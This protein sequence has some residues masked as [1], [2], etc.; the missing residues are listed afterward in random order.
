MVAELLP[1]R[2]LLLGVVEVGRCRAAL[3]RPCSERAAVLPETGRAARDDEAPTLCVWRPDITVASSL[4]TRT[5]NGT[6]IA[7]DVIH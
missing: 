4:I 6:V 3:S 5:P 1:Q 7:E 2:L